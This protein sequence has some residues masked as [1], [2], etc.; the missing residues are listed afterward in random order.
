MRRMATASQ[1]TCPIQQ[2]VRMPI[3]GAQGRNR[4]RRCGYSYIRADLNSDGESPG[5]PQDSPET[6]EIGG[7]PTLPMLHLAMR[8]SAHP[9]SRRQGLCM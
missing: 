3:S 2:L 5:E 4:C 1:E 8:H 6:P 7:S 9:G